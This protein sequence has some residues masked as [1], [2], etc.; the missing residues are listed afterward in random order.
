MQDA[1]LLYLLLTNKI[2]PYPANRYPTFTHTHTHIHTH[3]HTHTLKQTHTHTHTLT[4][5]VWRA[6]LYS[7]IT[8]QRVS[9]MLLK[10]QSTHVY[11][12]NQHVY[13]KT[14]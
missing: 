6:T 13:V 11:C 10:Q 14:M 2:H 8:A 5:M 12:Y 9:T 3:T 1:K 7:T 4:Y